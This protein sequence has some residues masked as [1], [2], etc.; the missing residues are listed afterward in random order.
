SQSQSQSQRQSQSQGVPCFCATESKDEGGGVP[1]LLP[2]QRQRVPCLRL[3]SHD[4]HAH[5]TS[6]RSTVSL[7]VL[8][9]KGG[10]FRRDTV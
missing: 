5:Q 8:E 1:H 3:R 4:W 9:L 2:D 7:G 6:H 10:T